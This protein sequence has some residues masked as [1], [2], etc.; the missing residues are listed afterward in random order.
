VQDVLF[1]HICYCHQQGAEL[2]LVAS[3][4]GE[5]NSSE[6]EAYSNSLILPENYRFYSTKTRFRQRLIIQ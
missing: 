1:G 5:L 4:I 2:H 6:P 3:K